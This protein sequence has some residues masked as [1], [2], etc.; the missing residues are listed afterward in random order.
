[1][2]TW[3][4]QPSIT[5]NGSTPL[6]E[7]LKEQEEAEQQRKDI[8]L[9][10]DILEA[11]FGGVRGMKSIIYHK[12]RP[13]NPLTKAMIKRLSSDVKEYTMAEQLALLLQQSG[14]KTLVDRFISTPAMKKRQLERLL[15][16]NKQLTKPS[17]LLSDTVKEFKGNGSGD[18]SRDLILLQQAGI[19]RRKERENGQVEYIKVA[20]DEKDAAVALVKNANKLVGYVPISKRKQTSVATPP[21]RKQIETAAAKRPQSRSVRYTDSLTGV[22]D[23]MEEAFTE[24]K[25]I[26]PNTGLERFAEIFM[27]DRMKG[28]NA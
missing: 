1:M 24:F 20:T 7:H 25:K 10:R 17:F 3:E 9:S 13:K 18:P 16:F 23:G 15:G 21:A 19:L 6:N 12:S 5:V 14:E 26:F 4:G 28:A 8:A 2:P 11:G 27:A 22:F